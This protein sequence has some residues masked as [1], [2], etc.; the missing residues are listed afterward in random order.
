MN[1]ERTPRNNSVNLWHKLQ[2]QQQQT[3]VVGP[4][5]LHFPSEN[6]AL[7]RVRAE[8]LAGWGPW[9]PSSDALEAQDI[10]L[11]VKRGAT[12]MLLRWFNKPEGDVLRWELSRRVRAGSGVEGLV[13]VFE[14]L[15][16]GSL[17]R[18]YR[19]PLGV[20]L[21]SARACSC[22][23]VL[24]TIL[25]ARVLLLSLFSF[26]VLVCFCSLKVVVVVVVVVVL[27]RGRFLP[28]WLCRCNTLQCIKSTRSLGTARTFG[29]T[30]TTAGFC[31]REKFPV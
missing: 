26:L 7:F 1:G 4:C 14:W 15:A 22:I 6:R 10:I 28:C 5:R 17:S 2:R 31:V 20:R 23:S 30:T 27:A 8:N 9:S 3:F 16:R 21:C 11:P 24:Q 13:V 29:G 18:L 12:Q 25:R 19:Y